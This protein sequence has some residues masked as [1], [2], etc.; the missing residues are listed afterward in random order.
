M[1]ALIIVGMLGFVYLRQVVGT[2]SQGT[3]VRELEAQIIELQE[4]QQELN[5]E[6]AELRSLQTVEE[7]T[8]QLNLVEADR[9]SYLAPDADRVALNN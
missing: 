9:V 8:Q 2:A 3:D 7:K 1:V 6:G 5:L 4:K